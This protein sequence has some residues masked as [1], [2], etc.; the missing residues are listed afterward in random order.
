LIEK[1]THPRIEV[2]RTALYSK[3][4]YPRPTIA[5]ILD[6][7][8]GGTKIET[9]YSMRR[10]DKLEI[11]IGIPPQ[12]IRC[13]GEVIH[14]SLPENGKVKAGIQFDELSAHDKLH[15]G[16]HLLDLIEQRS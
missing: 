13:R 16:Q 10:G 2:S 5:S 3:D 6:L 12:A 1:R 15:L 4:I 11:T 9:L 8:L 7:S 14:V